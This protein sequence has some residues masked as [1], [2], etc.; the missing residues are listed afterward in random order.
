MG[1]ASKDKVWVGHAAFSGLH[2]WSKLGGSNDDCSMS[3]G[4]ESQERSILSY[5]RMLF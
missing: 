3:G 1:R 5:N 4:L 2:F